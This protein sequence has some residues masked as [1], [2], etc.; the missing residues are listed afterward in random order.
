MRILKQVLRVGEAPLS[1]SIQRMLRAI[2]TDGLGPAERHFL[3]SDSAMMVHWTHEGTAGSTRYFV[4]V[5]RTLEPSDVHDHLHAFVRI[6]D[7]NGHEAAFHVEPISQEKPCHFQKDRKKPFMNAVPAES[8]LVLQILSHIPREL[9][10]ALPEPL[11][12]SFRNSHAQKIKKVNQLGND[13]KA[14]TVY[15]GIARWLDSLAKK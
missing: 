6:T 2:Q 4:T 13:R 7:E 12:P 10:D 8:N 3:Q 14:R 9:A 5:G 15:P 1:R 11:P